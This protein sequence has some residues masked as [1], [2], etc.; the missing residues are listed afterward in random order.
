MKE[1]E[2]EIL[3][4]GGGFV[5]AA[6]ALAAARL[7][8]AVLLADGGGAAAERGADPR[9][10]MLSRASRALLE[11]L[12]ALEGMAARLQPVQEMVI[13]HGPRSEDGGGGSPVFLGFPGAARKGGG[14][15]GKQPLAWM[16]ENRH[17]G[18]GLEKALQQ[19]KGLRRMKARVAACTA[20]GRNRIEAR[21]EGGGRVRARLC[22]AADGGNSRLRGDVGIE[23][24][25][26]RYEGRALTA[27]VAH[28]WEHGGVAQEHFLPGGPFAVLPLPG[29][30]SSLV[31]V[32][33]ERAAAALARCPEAVFLQQARRRMGGR[34]GELSLAST[35][36]TYP[37]RLL[38]ARR[39]GAEGLLLA[40]DA[41]HA[42][43]PLA[44][45]GLNMG[46]KDVL[47]LEQLLA[48]ARRLGLGLDFALL[49]E[50]YERMRRFDNLAMAMV[51][52][53]TQRLFRG[54]GA[55]LRALR[56]LCLGTA[57]AS[58][59]IRAMGERLAG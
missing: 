48:E 59:W 52:D 18:E 53:G 43:H 3:V 31:W 2:T 11:R 5:G 10:S 22:I 39:Y 33:T 40:G 42:V 20:A 47:A 27:V 36:L 38:L 41:A 55:V 45:Q 49:L 46:L 19:G 54:E 35:R 51:T 29:R 15:E 34:Q 28:E 30:R 13:S 25:E 8:F 56:D 58:P 21:L 23:T 17:L 6:L 26:W 16:A 32:E 7:G 24:V 14:K 44:G 37:V 12:G 9:A 50:R 4:V 1:T 57:Q